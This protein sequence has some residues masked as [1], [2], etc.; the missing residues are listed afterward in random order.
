MRTIL[1]L[2]FFA[3]SSLPLKGQV[4]ISLLLGDKLNSGKIE[5]GLDGGI[6][7]P[8]VRG[9]S[10]SEMRGLFNLGFY[11]DFKL[12][13]PQW[14]IHTGVIV[15]STMGA[16]NLPVYLLGNP[17]L[18]NAFVDGNV[19]RKMNYFNVPIAMKYM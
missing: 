5:F 1:P 17:D 15:K 7:F 13:N 3:L 8:D 16:N 2:L 9:L 6:N 19:Q 10:E 14:M 4:L 11:F 18:D 12:K